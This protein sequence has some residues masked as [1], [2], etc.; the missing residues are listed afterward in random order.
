LRWPSSSF[1]A[2]QSLDQLWEHAH[3]WGRSPTLRNRSR[4]KRQRWRRQT[5]WSYASEFSRANQLTARKM[6]DHDFGRC[7]GH[8]ERVD[9]TPGASTFLLHVSGHW[10]SSGCLEMFPPLGISSCDLKPRHVRGFLLL[11]FQRTSGKA[12]ALGNRSLAPTRSQTA[13]VTSPG[14]VG[15]P[16][17][18]RAPPAR[19]RCGGPGRSRRSAPCLISRVGFRAAP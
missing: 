9:F 19:R 5:W 10:I 2:D 14:P 17:A 11:R 13:L 8:H 6:S 7:D 16:M 1:G 12:T 3:S 18:G 4:Q 15:G